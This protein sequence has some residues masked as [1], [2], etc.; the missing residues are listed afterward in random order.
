MI[1]NNTSDIVGR[2]QSWFASQCDG[3]WEHQHG[4]SISTL[5][6]PGW[7]VK[8]DLSGTA[9]SHTVFVDI[10]QQESCNNWYE[11]R[12]EHGNFLAY[13]GPLN[14]VTVLLIFLDWASPTEAS[15]NHDV[16]L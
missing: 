9:L 4:V 5:D 1:D 7:S 12:V 6:N 16:A 13:C 14:L 15:P 10:K 2:L 8:I 3:Q 11:C